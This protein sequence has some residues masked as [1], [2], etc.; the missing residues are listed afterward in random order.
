MRYD[1][2][3]LY[4]NVTQVRLPSLSLASILSDTQR[5]TSPMRYDCRYIYPN[6][7][8]VRLPSLSLASILPGTEDYI[9]YEVQQQLQLSQC[10]TGEAAQPLPGLHIARFRSTCHL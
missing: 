1:Y 4:P 10:D 9:T 3:Y 5:T 6:V 7:T 8:Q 2:G